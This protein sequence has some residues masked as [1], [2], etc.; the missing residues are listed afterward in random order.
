MTG[1][2]QIEVPEGIGF[3][4]MCHAYLYAYVITAPLRGIITALVQKRCVP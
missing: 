2:T 3:F 4:M 1:G